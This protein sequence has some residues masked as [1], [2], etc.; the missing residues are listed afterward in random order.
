[1]DLLI[2]TALL[3][4]GETLITL[5][6]TRWFPQELW[7]LSLAPAVTAIVM[8]GNGCFTSMKSE[9]YFGD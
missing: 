4:I 7:T 5:G 6:A 3:C 9:G 1:M 8:V 2:F